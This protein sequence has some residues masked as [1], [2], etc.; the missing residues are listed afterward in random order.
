MKLI[1]SS[2]LFV[3]AVVL[4]AGLYLVV[5]KGEGKKSDLKKLCSLPSQISKRVQQLGDYLFKLFGSR[6]EATID[7]PTAAPTAPAA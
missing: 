4:T 1:I 5:R 2:L 7:Q 3:V 6:P